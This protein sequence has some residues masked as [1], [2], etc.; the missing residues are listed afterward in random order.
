MYGWGWGKYVIACR[1]LVCHALC[2]FYGTLST[3][4][5]LSLVVMAKQPVSVLFSVKLVE[6]ILGTYKN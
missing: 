1:P 3:L 6:I 2:I 4:V 5:S